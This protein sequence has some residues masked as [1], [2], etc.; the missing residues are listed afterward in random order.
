[1]LDTNVGLSDEQLR[2]IAPSIFATHAAPTVSDRYLY[3][4]SYTVVRQLRTAGLVPI[5][6]REGRKKQPD[7]REYALHEVRFAPTGAPTAAPELGDVRPEILLLNSHDRTSGMA[8]QAGMHRLICTNGMRVMEQDMGFKVRHSGKKGMDILMSG[9]T[10]LKHNLHRVFEVAGDWNKLQLTR[11]QQ[12]S[13]AR[14]A[15]E[16]RGTSLAISPDLVLTPRR[17]LDNRDDLWSVFN[18]VQE[19][20]TKGGIVGRTK[21]N[22]ATSLK[23]IGTLAADIDWNTKLWA[24]ASELAAE[25]KPSSISMAEVA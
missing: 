3:L 24:A 21:T 6:A 17:W 4:P 11:E 12:L 19:N 5:V 20:I 13:F 2:T 15:L 16:I 1:M 22:R 23:A 14:Q 8:F 9:L 25:V 18:R 7:G 10:N